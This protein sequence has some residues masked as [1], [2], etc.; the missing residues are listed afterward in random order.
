MLSARHLYDKEIK[1]SEQRQCRNTE[2]EQHLYSVR[3]N[4]ITTEDEK[5]EFPFYTFL[6]D[7]LKI[8]SSKTYWA[9]IMTF[10]AEN[11]FIIILL[12]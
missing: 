6:E 5:N 11:V 3:Y 1:M 10:R 7:L 4:K 8:L 12:T 9:V 2:R